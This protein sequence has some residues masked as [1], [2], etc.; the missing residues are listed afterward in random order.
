MIRTDA[1]PTLQLTQA[2]RG[3]SQA[4]EPRSLACL[5]GCVSR[6]GAGRGI[7]LAG[8]RL[9]A[10]VAVYGEYVAQ[11][12]APDTIE[13]RA[14]VTGLVQRQ[15]FADGAQVKKGDLLY[16]IVIE[17]GDQAALMRVLRQV[18]QARA[19]RMSSVTG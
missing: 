12:Q 11:T 14:Q 2:G 10:P 1:G 5:H 19:A 4:R 18:A 6:R 9:P 17:E 13:I 16:A 3:A 7:G 15:A 8:F